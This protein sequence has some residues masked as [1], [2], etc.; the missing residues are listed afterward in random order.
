VGIVSY[1][2]ASFDNFTNLTYLTISKV[3]V[4]PDLI[5][6]NLQFYYS[7]SNLESYQGTGNALIDMSKNYSIIN[8][9]LIVHL[10]AG[11]KSSYPGSG[12]IWY[13]LV[14]NAYG[15]LVNNV[16]FVDNYKASYLTF[17][18][19][20][21]YIQL[22][23]FTFTQSSSAN[24]YTI[25][26]SAKL[27]STSSSRRQLISPDNAGF[28]WGFGAGDGTKF[29]IFSGD[30]IQTGR[31]QDTNW[32]IFA[33]QW[34]SAGT[35]LY[36]DD[37]IDI[38]T[39][40]I[41][42]DSSINVTNIGRNPSFGEY[43]HGTVSTVLIYDRILTTQELTQ[44]Y[45]SLK[46]TTFP[47][48]LNNVT[49][50]SDNS[51]SLVF[52]G[53][54]SYIDVP[55]T[56]TAVTKYSISVWVK[57]TTGGV[58]IDNRGVTGSSGR[59]IVLSIGNFRVSYFPF[60][61]DGQIF[62][63][64]APTIVADNTWHHIVCVLD[65]TS[66]LILTDQNYNQY[67]KI[68]IDNVLQVI[69]VGQILGS[70]AL[71]FT[72]LDNLQIGRS[73]SLNSYFSGQIGTTQIFTKA[74]TPTEV[75][76]IY[77]GEENPNIGTHTI[78]PELV[79]IP[80]GTIPSLENVNIQNIYANYNLRHLSILSSEIV[81]NTNAFTNIFYEQF[82]TASSLNFGDTVNYVKSDTT[83][84]V[85]G[86]N[87]FNEPPPINAGAT[88][89][90]I[91]WFTMGPLY[92]PFVKYTGI[93]GFGMKRVDNQ[94]E[95]KVLIYQTQ[96]SKSSTFFWSGFVRTTP[97]YITT[98]LSG[99][100]FA[101]Q[102]NNIYN[103]YF[104]VIDIRNGIADTA[105]FQLRKGINNLTPIAF[106]AGVNITLD[107]WYRITAEWKTNGDITVRLYS[108]ENILLSTLSVND[109]TYSTGYIGLTSY[110]NSLFDNFTNINS[111]TAFPST[112]ATREFVSL[113]RIAPGQVSITQSGSVLTGEATGIHRIKTEVIYLVSGSISSLEF[114]PT[115]RINAGAVRILHQGFTN[116]S[117]L[118]S[119]TLLAG[120]KNL[121]PT[122]ILTGQILGTHTIKPEVAKILHQSLINTNILGTHRINPG[123]VN[124]NG[125]TSIPSQEQ[126][127]NYRLIAGVAKILPTSFTVAHVLGIH[128]VRP[129]VV[130]ILSGTISSREFVNTHS[131]SSIARLIPTS[132]LT[133]QALGLH[134]FELKNNISAG[135][136]LS[137]EALGIHL[138]RA[139][140]KIL[141]PTL[142]NNSYVETPKFIFVFRDGILKVMILPM[143][144]IGMTTND[145]GNINVS[146]RDISTIEEQ[147]S[148]KYLLENQVDNKYIMEIKIYDSE[149]LP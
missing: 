96:Y 49:Y 131:L 114:L 115:Q 99:I 88:G 145:Y 12:N 85:Y 33:G 45:N 71:P 3:K 118:G 147:I 108:F 28:D 133:G 20:N 61:S 10:E 24:Q 21:Q 56:Q 26:I 144:T 119:H 54:N 59:S 23:N 126:F 100:A 2:N 123:N 8:T 64:T 58:I 86:L 69:S 48:L 127:E 70:P 141:P 149:R 106:D 29:S 105:G 135:T 90:G 16:G 51:G 47:A 18:G 92:K 83:D 95:N 15:E 41:G 146:V 44:V 53:T 120:G 78:K 137:A 7:P 60:N 79:N 113:H 67:I 1:S 63:L 103:G 81:P 74:L 142:I 117:T 66:G 72:G 104:A 46:I 57:T 101:I 62:S 27:N 134:R 42:Y 37:V 5:S 97:G 19:T 82:E 11:N 124:V 121:S 91:Y 87:T 89:F 52:N 130:N 38:N 55:Y 122:T 136:I 102:P 140:H 139:V 132:I 148:S 43:W 40:T 107:A 93:S 30:N 94:S 77:L 6:D 32:H 9:G 111:Q 128:T 84:Q 73:V 31:N 75:R 35:K 116:I 138:F 76:G 125:V 110:S 143:G 39:T 4:R 14:G 22:N 68:Y 34:S 129:G 50:S 112:I 65:G 13:S 36:I 17:N 109:N 80:T 25:I 98:G